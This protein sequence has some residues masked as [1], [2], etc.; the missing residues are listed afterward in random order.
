MGQGGRADKVEG[1][2]PSCGVCTSKVEAVEEDAVDHWRRRERRHQLLEKPRARARVRARAVLGAETR[3]WS[4]PPG[5]LEGI[6]R[7]CVS[8]DKRGM[9]F[10]W[11]VIRLGCVAE[12]QTK[13]KRVGTRHH[14]LFRAHS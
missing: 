11:G 1:S 6:G 4:A 5:V 7:F 13:P 12:Q 9:C 3:R 2:V 10:V 8:F 14:W